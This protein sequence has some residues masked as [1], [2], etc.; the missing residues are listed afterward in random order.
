MGQPI[1]AAAGFQPADF[2][3][4]PPKRRLQAELPAPQGVFIN[5]GGPSHGHSVEDAGPRSANGTGS[6][7][8]AVRLEGADCGALVVMFVRFVL[9]GLAAIVC[10]QAQVTLTGRVVDQNDAPVANARVSVHRGNESPVQTYSGPSGG[11]ALRVSAADT[12]LIDV[13][14]AGYFALKDRPV[15]ATSEI[16]LVLNQEQEV[17][18]SVTVG[19]LPSPVIRSRRNASKA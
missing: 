8:V 18:Q 16:T 4:K 3:N 11:F 10:A 12:Y 9:G 2:T 13:D 5:F 14:R 1:L 6:L 15:Q 17:F 19:V 7:A